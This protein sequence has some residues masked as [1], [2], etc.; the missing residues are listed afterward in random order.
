M[1]ATVGR[2][3]DTTFS[4]RRFTIASSAPYDDFRRR[5]EEAVPPF[6][7][8]AF[9]SLVERKAPWSEVLDL[10]DRSAP[11]GFLNYHILDAQP[12]MSLAGDLAP[13]VEYLMGNHTVAER[14][15]RHDPAILAYVPLRTVISGFDGGVR[16]T[17][18]QPSSALSSFGNDQITAVGVELDRKVA[19]LLAHLDVAVPP[20]LT[21]S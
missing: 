20:A 13:C 11:H 15:F 4:A 5:Y 18:E 21:G 7:A 16:F 14:M 17:V 6:D 3:I 2:I 10:M 12:L 19:K 9:G 8:A 1:T